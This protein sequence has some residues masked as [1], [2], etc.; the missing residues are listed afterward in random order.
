MKKLLLIF[1]VLFM[2]SLV[3]AAAPSLGVFKVNQDIELRQTCTIN[4]TFC[5]LCNISSVDYPNGS[6]I[7]SD[8]VLTK[9]AGDFNY[10]LNSTYVT[11]LGVYKNNGYCK[12]GSDVIKNWV[13]YFEVTNTG[14]KVSGTNTI[15]VAAFL[16]LTI[17]CLVLGFTFKT[18]Y[19]LF[20][21]FFYFCALLLSIL[22]INSARIIASESAS[23]STMTTSGLLIGIVLFAVFMIIIFVYAFIDVIRTLKNK[24][25]LRWDY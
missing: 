15:L 13:Y 5:D 14:E 7:I 1:G 25:E 3:S 19:W 6:R 17:V 20:K 9:R 11:D 22:S 23:L 24:R 4:G 8:V 21:A 10:T 16:I 2:L 12:Y 18:D